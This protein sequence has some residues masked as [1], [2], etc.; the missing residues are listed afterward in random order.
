MGLPWTCCG[1]GKT[2]VGRVAVTGG[3]QPND[4][5]APVVAYKNGANE[6]DDTLTIA[7]TTARGAIA[8]QAVDDANSY[9]VFE[10]ET[11]LDVYVKTAAA[12][13][14]SAAGKAEPYLVYCDL[15]ANK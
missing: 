5:T 8:T 11:Q 4:Q 3:H 1:G 2:S 12:D 14:G 9:D 15:P 13:A 7:D 6:G 10:A